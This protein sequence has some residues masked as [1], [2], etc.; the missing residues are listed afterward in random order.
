MYVN[1]SMSEQPQVRFP[2]AKVALVSKIVFEN[3][4]FNSHRSTLNKYT[5]LG[6]FNRM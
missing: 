6:E 3:N 1:D 4:D 5:S 2:W